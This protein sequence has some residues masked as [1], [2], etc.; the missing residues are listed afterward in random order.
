MQRPVTLGQSSDLQQEEWV[1]TGVADYP[2]EAYA[3]YAVA[4]QN[5]TTLLVAGGKMITD[6]HHEYGPLTG[7]SRQVFALNLESG[8]WTSLADLPEDDDRRS[9]KS[10]GF[11]HTSRSG[12]KSFVVYGYKKVFRLFRDGGNWERQA[13]AGAKQ[14]ACLAMIGDGSMILSFESFQNRIIFLGTTDVLAELPTTFGLLEY[15][16]MLVDKDGEQ[17]MRVFLDDGSR[18][19]VVSSK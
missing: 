4:A 7:F 14:D 18:A 15:G 1:D 12:E 17:S 2:G 6:W 10:F 16:L 9:S 13:I 5:E 11:M 19:V 8:S 3:R